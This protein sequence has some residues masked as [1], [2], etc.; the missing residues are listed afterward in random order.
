[1]GSRILPLLTQFNSDFWTAG[2][3]DRLE[4]L[5]CRTCSAWI[6]P[7]SPNCPECL[8]K[9]LG[10]QSVSG[11]GV[12]EA[13]SVNYQA[14]KPDDEVPYIIAIVSLNDCGGV[15]LTTN[16]VGALKDD[17]QIGMPV[18]VIF[19]HCEDVWIPLFTPA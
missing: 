11:Y 19:E 13:I 18:R 17:I 1:M 10:M 15:R 6:H 14:W 16:I 2:K 8:G 9:N 3:N 5:R 12:I 7:P 4:I